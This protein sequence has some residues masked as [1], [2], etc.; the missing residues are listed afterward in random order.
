VA[1]IVRLTLALQRTA[2]P[3]GS[4]TVRII[5]L[6]LLQ[7]TGR[8]RWRSL[9]LVDYRASIRP[10]KIL[11]YIPRHAFIVFFWWAIF[12]AAVC[13]GSIIAFLVVMP[14]DEHGRQGIFTAFRAYSPGFLVAVLIAGAS[15]RV[16][17]ATRKVSDKT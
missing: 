8:F 15:Y 3:L 17:R 10:M 11:N 2:A 6:R 7:P 12:T 5:C 1:I 9:S 13:L 4:R 16:L 14:D